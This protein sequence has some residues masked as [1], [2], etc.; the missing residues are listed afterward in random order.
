M[1]DVEALSERVVIIKGGRKAF[2]GDLGGLR[3][4]AGAGA[5]AGLDEVM[6]K[7]FSDEG[8]S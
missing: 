6:A 3:S 2:D 8:R 7:V 5:D 4:H 1:S